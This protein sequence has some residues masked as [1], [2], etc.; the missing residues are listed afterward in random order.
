MNAICQ[1]IYLAGY[2]GWIM[3]RIIR[4]LVAGTQ[5]H[6]AWFLGF[7][8]FFKQDGIAYGSARPYPDRKCSKGNSGA[9]GPNAAPHPG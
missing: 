3:P 9:R 1:R 4:K 2:G 8:G 5:V 6:R 7:N